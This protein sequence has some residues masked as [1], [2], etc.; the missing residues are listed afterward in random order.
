MFGKLCGPSATTCR[1]RSKA[2][3]PSPLLTADGFRAEV[4]ENRSFSGTKRYIQN[5]S[6]SLRENSGANPNWAT[7]DFE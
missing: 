5:K 6:W 7:K 1:Q 4:F 2:L 3:L